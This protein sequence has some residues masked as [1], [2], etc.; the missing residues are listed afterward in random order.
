MK[1]VET[2]LQDLKL[3]RGRKNAFEI[4]VSNKGMNVDDEDEDFETALDD[5]GDFEDIDSIDDDDEDY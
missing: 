1:T 2:D 4:P 5:L 3:T